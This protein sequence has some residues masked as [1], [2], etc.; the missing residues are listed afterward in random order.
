MN[1]TDRCRVYRHLRIRFAFLLNRDPDVVMEC[2]GWAWVF[3]AGAMDAKSIDKA[4]RAQATALGW[5]RRGGIGAW[6]HRERCMP[7]TQAMTDQDRVMLRS[8]GPCVPRVRNA[9]FKQTRHVP[10]VYRQAA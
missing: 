1:E 6:Y 7:V 5:R 2:Y 4:C 8:N 3:S 9:R 10:H